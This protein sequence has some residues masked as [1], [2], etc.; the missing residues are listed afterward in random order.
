MQTKLSQAIKDTPLGQEADEILRRCVHCGFCTATCP[1][2]Q[3]LG[4]ELDSPR[5]RIYLIKEMLERDEA[6]E[7][8]QLHL[9]RCLT[10]R[11]CETTCPSGV[12]Y[13]KLIDIGRQIVDEKVP[14]SGIQK[15]K[16]EVLRKTLNA[17]WFAPA[18]RL[19]QSVRDWLPETIKRKVVHRQDPG[20]TPD[21][22][23][24]DQQVLMLNGCVQ[25]GMMPNIDAAM[26]RVLDR[27]GIGSIIVAESG[28]CGALNFHLDAQELA[29]AQ[30][31]ANIDAWWPLIESGKVQALVMNASGCGAMV[32]EY[33]HHL[34]LDPAYAQK[35]QTVSDLVKD[36]AEF[37][38]PQA[39]RLRELLDTQKF[40]RQVAYHPPCTLQHWQGLRPVSEELLRSIGLDLKPF[41]EAHLCCGSAGT[42]SVLQP[43][44]A[45]SLRDRK[46]GH[47]NQAQ[48]DVILSSN[49]GCIGHLQSGTETPVQHWIEVVDRAL[50]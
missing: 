17:P 32:R 50:H 46:L 25:P 9:D 28:C 29:R 31:R 3:V 1:T 14:R 48:P 42:Y 15:V 8:T 47:L 27:L 22:A 20:I 23:R 13:G 49:I 7:A 11:N 2:Y 19:G 10:C 21:T 34:R 41:S 18:Y 36:I 33:G 24:H 40:P 30:M 5:G 43:E 39:D 37:L 12:E 44:I 26:I 16:R 45:T 38:S 6:T 35:A 4:D